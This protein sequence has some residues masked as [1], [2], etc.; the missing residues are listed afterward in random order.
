MVAT[1]AGLASVE[2]ARFPLRHITDVW[3]DLLET[4]ARF[5]STRFLRSRSPGENELLHDVRVDTTCRSTGCEDS[6]TW[7][8]QVLIARS[9]TPSDG[10]DPNLQ[11]DRYV[12][13]L[14]N[15]GEFLSI[16]VAT[17]SYYAG[18]AHYVYDMHCRTFRAGH[19]KPAKLADVMGKASAR[20]LLRKL[21]ELF[22][23]CDGGTGSHLPCSQYRG[24]DR[25]FVAA[26]QTDFRLEDSPCGNDFRVVV[27]Q[28]S[29]QGDGT[30]VREI[31][32]DQVPAT[33]LLQ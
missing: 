22:N 7:Q 28:P 10:D 2:P 19:R 32:L 23:P 33:L 26:G 3:P 1:P 27:C 18:A 9:P 11:A 24:E 12:E 30:E 6:L 15:D 29:Q 5:A 16:N 17:Q 31:P 4:K 8:G 13:V 21:P 25:R 14:R 20:L